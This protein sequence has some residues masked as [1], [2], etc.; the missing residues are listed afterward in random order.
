MT[1]R[2]EM[3]GAFRKMRESSSAFGTHSSAPASLAL[4]SSGGSELQPDLA[5]RSTSTS[6]SSSVL[7][8]PSPER[9]CIS[10]WPST[11][12]KLSLRSKRVVIPTTGE[13]SGV[14]VPIIPIVFF[15][16]TMSEMRDVTNT[17]LPKETHE[18]RLQ[19]RHVSILQPAPLDH[20]THRIGT[21]E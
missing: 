4:C 21:L 3:Y 11:N 10:S 2:S 9:T 6:I 16:C 13:L 18:L 7:P 20:L 12:Q 8:F 5:T 19:K 17:V 15:L 1:S 14:G